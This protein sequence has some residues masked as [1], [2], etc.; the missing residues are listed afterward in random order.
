[1]FK[2]DTTGT[3]SLLYSFTGGSDGKCPMAGLAR[4][5]ADDFYGTTFE[6][7][8]TGCQCGTVFK[9]DKTG[10]ETTVYTFTG[11]A[12]GFPSRGNLVLDSAGNLYGTTFGG[13]TYFGV[14]YKL[15]PGSGGW[16]ETVLHTFVGSDGG[17][18][19]GL[20][21]DSAGNLYGTTSDFGPHNAGTIFKLTP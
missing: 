3:E 5:R 18:A 10:Q 14:I 9:L 20:I 1:V 11:G 19:S 4:G 8:G 13:G 12:D 15:T 7:G 2:L 16:T 6:G 17:S 21:R